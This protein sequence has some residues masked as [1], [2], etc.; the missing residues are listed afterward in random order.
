MICHIGPI[1]WG[2]RRHR[3]HDLVLT[4]HIRGFSGRGASGF[5]PAMVRAPSRACPLSEIPGNSRRNSMAANTSPPRSKA[6]RTA[7]GFRLGDD[8]RPRGMA[9]SETGWQAELL[10][11]GFTARQE[12]VV[13]A[14]S[15]AA[16]RTRCDLVPRVERRRE[17]G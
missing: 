2:A 5:Q 11:S 8:E 3:V 16:R 7:A 4:R 13:M 9:V 15:G 10:L 6:E 14:I 12:L 17:L 1:A